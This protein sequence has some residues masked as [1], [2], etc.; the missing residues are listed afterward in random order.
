MKLYDKFSKLKK[1]EG[2][3]VYQK[4]SHTAAMMDVGEK[5]TL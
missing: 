1:T 5:K 4:Q 3:L 2:I